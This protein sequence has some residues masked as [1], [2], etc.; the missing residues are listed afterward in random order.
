MDYGKVGQL[1]AKHGRH[2][3]T[4]NGGIKVSFR[5][6]VKDVVEFWKESF[7]F[8]FHQDK[9]MHRYHVV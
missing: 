4:D 9:N 2:I 1:K 5:V 8:R 7:L 3:V 6:T